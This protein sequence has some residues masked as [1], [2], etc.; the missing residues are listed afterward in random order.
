MLFRGAQRPDFPVLLDLLYQPH[1]INVIDHQHRKEYHHQRHGHTACDHLH[2]RIQNP[3]GKISVFR[4]VFRIDA[5]GFCHIFDGH[6]QVRGIYRHTVRQGEINVVY[7]LIRRV[8]RLVTGSGNVGGIGL[9]FL[10]FLKRLR[11]TADDKLLFLI[12]LLH[13]SPEMNGH[14]ISRSGIG[15]AQ[16][17]KHFLLTCNLIFLLG[18][19]SLL[20]LFF[21]VGQLHRFLVHPHHGNGSCIFNSAHGSGPSDPVKFAPFL[22]FGNLL[23]IYIGVRSIIGTIKFLRVDPLET[24]LSIA[25]GG[26]GGKQNRGQKNRKYDQYASGAVFP[27]IAP[28][29][30]CDCFHRSS[31]TFPSSITRILSAI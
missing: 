14:G 15:I 4:R 22:H 3:H 5:A 8:K 7:P 30:F 20:Q 10:L 11:N 29:K 31:A 27:V 12:G 19:C 16:P 26:D 25:E 9:I 18:K 13:I 2:S 1:L 23:F 6:F 28:C 24:D 21:H 17:F